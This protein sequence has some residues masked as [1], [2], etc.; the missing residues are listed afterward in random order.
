MS[1]VP[2]SAKICNPYAAPYPARR[3]RATVPLRTPEYPPPILSA[4]E[5]AAEAVWAA[6]ARSR[7]SA[8]LRA[9]RS[10]HGLRRFE[11]E[12]LG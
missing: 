3:T 10:L 7:P 9:P 11:E 2:Q 6:L 4:A 5:E 12:A 8:A 1:F